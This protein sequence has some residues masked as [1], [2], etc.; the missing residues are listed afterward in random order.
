MTETP[1]TRSL[2]FISIHCSDS[3]NYKHDSVDV[4]RSWHVSK[5]P[6]GRGWADIGYHYFIKG[7]GV[8]ENGRALHR[9]PAA[10]RGYNLN[11]IAI[12]LHGKRQ[13]QMEQ[14]ESCARL[15]SQLMFLHQ[16]PL[17]NIQGHSHWE[18]NKTCPNFDVGIIRKL[19]T[20][21]FS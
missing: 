14:F 12:C 9:I 10:V 2:K 18:K 1:I 13:F 15:C 6:R 16:I 21:Q 7:N 19:I 11:M 20:E 5:P 3:D 17:K 8:I 4:V